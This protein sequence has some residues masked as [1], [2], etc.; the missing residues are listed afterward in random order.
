[1]I[2]AECAHIAPFPLRQLGP[3]QYIQQLRSSE[4]SVRPSALEMTR[5]HGNLM[6]ED[7]LAVP[8]RYTHRGPRQ[9]CSSPDGT[10]NGFFTPGPPALGSSV[11]VN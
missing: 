9:A 1:M 4:K 5:R 2:F 3:S 10:L 11:L 6:T 7:L 8:E